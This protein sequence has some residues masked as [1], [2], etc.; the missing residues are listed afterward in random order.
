MEDSENLVLLSSKAIETVSYL[1]R[2]LTVGT[3]LIR[4][5]PRGEL[6][7]DIPLLYNGFALDRVHFNPKTLTPSPKGKPTQ[8]YVQI[9]EKSLK[10][11]A[12]K[13]LQELRVLDATEYREPERAWIVPLAW[14]NFI[15]AH[16]KVSHDGTQILPDRA[17]TEEVRKNVL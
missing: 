6:H 2:F 9:D 10:E 4:R 7:V 11:A 3:P 13:A 8:P 5:G 16:I 15:V 14:K 12:E 1:L 17:L